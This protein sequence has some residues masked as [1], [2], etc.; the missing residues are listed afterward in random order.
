[1]KYD[2]KIY[3]FLLFLVI[4]QLIICEINDN[5]VHGILE[6]G[7]YSL[8]DVAD[9]LNLSLIVSTSG[10]IYNGTP[11]NRISQTTANF[12][13]STF[14]A[15][16][17]EDYILASCLKDSLLTKIRISTGEYRSLL[18][19]S[20]YDSITASNSSC[21]ISIYEDIVFIA[22][23]QYNLENRTI[24]SFI[25][26][27]IENKNDIINGPNIT[28]E[29]KQIFVYPYPYTRSNTSRDI[30]C[31]TIVEKNNNEYRLLCVHENRTDQNLI[32][33]FI[34]NKD[35]N[36]IQNEVQIDKSSNE[37]GF[38]V[39]YY[40]KYYIRCVL[41]KKMYDLYLNENFEIKK[42]TV[43]INNFESFPRLFAYSNNFVF[44]VRTD[45][46]F[47]YDGSYGGINYFLIYTF[48]I[49]YYLIFI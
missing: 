40:D 14:I 19:Y 33:A 11:S 15:V 12:N 21:C 43:E 48:S 37:F 6:E 26:L 42:V 2:L 34:I 4:I 35:F 46:S 16:C 23:S 7:G 45:T 49:N 30:S 31:E 44:C 36:E 32:Y 18:S 13:E 39:Y 20:D 29:D 28:D 22:I 17:N 47:Y 10:N 24:N 27:H 3:F 25:K 8:L 38:R 1:M 5:F 9:Y 41:R